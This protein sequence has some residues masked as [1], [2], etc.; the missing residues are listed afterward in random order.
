MTHLA[1]R[2]ATA[3]IAAAFASGASA[4]VISSNT[5]Y[6]VIDGREDSRTLEVTSHG[7]IT[8][9][10]L[11]IEFSKCD[12]PS[13]GPN[14]TACTGRGNPYEDEFS[15]VLAGPNGQRVSLI[16][17]WATYNGAAGSAGR[18]RVTF[19]D[20]AASAAGPKVKGGTFTPQEALSAF[21]GMDMF[22]SWTLYLTDYGS[23]DP[24]EFFSAQLDASYAQP[25]P[26][27]Q[28]PEPATLAMLGI[29]LF[30]VGAARR[31]SRK[32]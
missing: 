12:D 1:R 28:I 14:G 16:E 18:V 5:T 29:G 23:G 19:D 4:S 25:A 8:D 30:G 6:G 15:F 24:L 26:V 9:L 22:G 10:N 13:I 27:A 17:P 21:D 2:F 31:S 32:A 11:T 3:I 7:T 20:E